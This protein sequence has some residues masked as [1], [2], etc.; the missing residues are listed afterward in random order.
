MWHEEEL[1]EGTLDI[2]RKLIG[3]KQCSGEVKSLACNCKVLAIH[4]G[5]VYT[6]YSFHGGN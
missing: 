5:L 3:F 2:L 1:V 4:F 6:C